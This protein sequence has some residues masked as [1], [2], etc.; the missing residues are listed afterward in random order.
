MARSAPSCTHLGPASSLRYAT[1]D[2][3][4]RLARRSVAKAGPYVRALAEFNWCFAEVFCFSQLI[5]WL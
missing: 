2:K 1:A 4:G 3:L 5:E